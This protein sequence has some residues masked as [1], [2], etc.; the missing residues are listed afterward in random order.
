MSKSPVIEITEKQKSNVGVWLGQANGES[1]L[2][3]RNQLP[4]N[5]E[6]AAAEIPNAEEQFDMWK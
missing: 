2:P 6:H 4:V 1:M 5:Q 3:A